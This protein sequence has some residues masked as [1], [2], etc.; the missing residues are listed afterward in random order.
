L[1]FAAFRRA[2]YDALYASLLLLSLGAL[3]G[4]Y[5]RRGEPGGWQRGLLSGLALGL[6]WN[7]RAEY[8]LAALLLFFLAAAAWADGRRLGL[9]A[10]AR[11]WA[12]EWGV[13]A[14]VVAAVTLGVM[15]ANYLRWGVFATNQQNAPGFNAAYRALLRIQPDHPVRRAPI[16]REACKRAF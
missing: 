15:G 2:T 3:L 1:H 13:P 8:Q 12:A 5:R 14:A 7:T 16:T 4:Q 6:L 10:G 11:R 9:A